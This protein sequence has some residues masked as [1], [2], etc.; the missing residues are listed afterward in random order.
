MEIKQVSIVGAGVMGMG[1]AKPRRISNH[2]L[3]GER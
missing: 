1:I 3:T 2:V